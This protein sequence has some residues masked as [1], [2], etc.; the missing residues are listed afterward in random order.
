[1][2]RNSLRL[3][4]I[5][6]LTYSHHRYLSSS[7]AEL[8]VDPPKKRK[9]EK[10]V[11][12]QVQKDVAKHFSQAG[13]QLALKYPPAILARSK[14]KDV[15]GFYIADQYGAD[16]AFEVITK[17]LPDDKP[18][19]EVNPGL[20]MLSKRLINETKNKLILCEPDKF[21]FE[22]MKVS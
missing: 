2:L 16:K 7:V 4:S 9:R 20:G 5:R 14:K 13:R 18:I 12:P 10:K 19:Y 3:W 21:C 8:P 6:S 1:M 22:R 15:D 11:E 17:D